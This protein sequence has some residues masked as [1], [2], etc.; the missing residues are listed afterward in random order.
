PRTPS[1]RP[2]DQPQSPCGPRRMLTL[3]LFM[4]LPLVVV[5]NLATGGWIDGAHAQK[6]THGCRPEDATLWINQGHPLVIEDVAC[7][8]SFGG[9]HATHAGPL[10]LLYRSK[11]HL[12]VTGGVDHA[13]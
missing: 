13:P 11:A 3:D 6:V 7:L 10:Q 2:P 12:S 4:N 1:P 9:E 5:P 8:K